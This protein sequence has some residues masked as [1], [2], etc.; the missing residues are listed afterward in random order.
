M[1]LDVDVKEV[2]RVAVNEAK[3]VVVLGHPA[4]LTGVYVGVIEMGVDA[5]PVGAY[6]NCTAPDGAKPTLVVFTT[7]VRVTGWPDFAVEGFAVR[8]IVVGACATVIV[9]VAGPLLL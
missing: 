7:A 1:I 2:V 3:P 6:W 9:S 4:P 8:A 5:P